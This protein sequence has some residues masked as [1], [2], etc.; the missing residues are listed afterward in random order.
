ML[1]ILRRSSESCLVSLMLSSAMGC[2]SEPPVSEALRQILSEVRTKSAQHDVTEMVS[3]LSSSVIPF[4]PIKDVECPDSEGGMYARVAS[5]IHTVGYAT[6][7]D[8]HVQDWEIDVGCYEHAEFKDLNGGISL[9][10]LGNGT[11]GSGTMSGSLT[12]KKLTR[13][14]L[15]FQLT[16]DVVSGQVLS[17]DG[18]AC[19]ESVDAS[20]L[21]VPY[22]TDHQ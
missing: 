16:F 2:S 1:Y 13:C 9:H 21:T 12:T 17:I 19:G 8:S 22:L 15:D 18:S 11:T 4:F 14:K 7:V 10:L 6:Q 20:D 3:S 5:P